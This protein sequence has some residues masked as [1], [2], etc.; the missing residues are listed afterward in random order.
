[1][2]MMSYFLCI[3]ILAYLCLVFMFFSLFVCPDVILGLYYGNSGILVSHCDYVVFVFVV[4]L[5]VL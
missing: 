1:M 2:M 3:E 5:F 4:D